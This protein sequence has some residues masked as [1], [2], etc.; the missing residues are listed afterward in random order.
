LLRSKNHADNLNETGLSVANG[1]HYGVQGYKYGYIVQGEIIGH[2]SDGEPLLDVGKLQPVTIMLPVDE[3]ISKDREKR[4]DLL[5]KKGWSSEQIIDIAN[6]TFKIEELPNEP[7]ASEGSDVRF[8]RAAASAPG[9]PAQTASQR[10]DAII[11]KSAATAQPIDAMVKYL[12]KAVRI[13]RL[14]TAIYNKAGALLDRYTPEQIKAGLVSD[15]GIPEAVIDRRAAM[16]GTMRQQIRGAGDLI[17]KLSTLTRAESRLAYEWMNNADPQAA[18]HFE[19]QLP[20]E[21]VK[22]M[23]EVKALVDKLSQEAVKLGQLDP[24]AFK[25]NRFEYLRRSYVKHTTEL[26]QQESKSRTRSIAVLGDQYKGRGMTDA[27]PMSKIKNVAPEWWNRK[28][29]QGKADK[30]LKGEKFIRLERRAPNGQGTIPL[31]TIQGPGNTNPLR[32]GKLLEVMYWPAGETVP[33][34]YST[35][36]QSGTWEVRD[37]KGADL[38]L[39]RDFTKQERIAMGE[40]DEARYAI[41]KTLHGMIHDVE[42]GKYLEWLGQRYAVKT[43][44]QVPGKLVEAS[45]A[46]HTTF[47]Q[48]EWVQVPETKIAGTSVQKYGLLAGRYLPGPIWNDVRQLSGVHLGPELWREI[49]RSWKISKTALSPAVHL[50]NVMANMVMADWHDISAGHMLKALRLTLAANERDGKGL[51]GRTGNLA[52]RA[53]SA[54]REASRLIIN[55]F[56][57]SGGSIGTW[58]TSELAK[59]QLAPLLEELEKELGL[60]GNTQGVQV[61]T[62]VALQKLL[63]L[64]LPSAWDAFKPTKAGRAL[65]TEAKNMMALYEAED[66]IF[67]LAAWL[68]SKEGGASDAEAGKVARTSFLDYHINAP[69]VQ[70]MRNSVL[71]FVSF[72]YRAAPML[73][74][75]AAKKPWKLMKLAALA[76]ALNALGYALS[77]GDEDDERKWMPKEKAG[78]VLGMVPKLIRMPWND[79]NG[80]PVFLD[81]RRFIP[82]GDIFDTGQGSAALPVPPALVP[83]GPLGLLFEFALDKTQFT[84]KP[85]TLET[86]TPLEKATKTADWLYKAFAPNLVFLPGTYAWTGVANAGS[87]KTDSFGREQSVA[88]AMASSFGVKLASYPKDVLQLNAQRELQFKKMEIDKNISSLKRERQRNGIDQAEFTEKLQAQVDKKKALMEEFQKRASGR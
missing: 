61:G 19:A 14:T 10:A 17:D 74:E 32:K 26:T 29:Q 7:T 28:L 73:L 59:E 21:S 84:G 47:K 5:N 81:I 80:S 54:D 65:T 37:T 55:R 76:G 30:A 63:Q 87:G 1:V 13:D 43:A 18:A 8:S 72:T 23:A 16:Q 50:N 64:K 34:K 27:A 57:D 44:S 67:R 33:A 70:M 41:A 11:A 78:R 85:I 48:D 60:A 79:A 66:Q 12:T 15:Y 25:R 36:D 88:Q 24:E 46:M 2:G 52:A 49:L 75:T 58:A 53:G 45:T 82:V 69:W 38:I 62:M 6:G 4:E 3:I 9:T 83:G 20:P 71:P 35:W 42:T 68:K 77:G 40:I 51:L 56:T 22:V 39:W 31:V 86:D